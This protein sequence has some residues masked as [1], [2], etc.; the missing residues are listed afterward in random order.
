VQHLASAAGALLSSALLA[1]GSGGRLEG[2][3]RV[4]LFSGALSLALPFLLAAVEPR[5]RRREAA[6]P[7]GGA[8]SDAVPVVAAEP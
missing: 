8:R 5:I 2:M 3:W 4:A 6:W 1:T 7:T